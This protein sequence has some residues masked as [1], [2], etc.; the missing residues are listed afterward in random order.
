MK[1][2]AVFAALALSLAA[3]A[4]CE[5]LDFLNVGGVPLPVTTPTPISPAPMATPPVLLTV[6]P[7]APTFTPYPGASRDAALGPITPANAG[8]LAL[9]ATIPHQNA[10]DITWSPDGALLAVLAEGGVW[11]YDIPQLDT[12][13]IQLPPSTS[14]GV[15]SA[16]FSPDGQ[17]LAVVSAGMQGR[18]QVFSTDAWRVEADIPV[19]DGKVTYSPDG[20]YLAVMGLSAGADNLPHR[21]V[22]IRTVALDSHLMLPVEDWVVDLAFSSDG[23]QILTA[24]ENFSGTSC[25]DTGTAVQVRN[26]EDGTI[27]YTLTPEGECGYRWAA[28]YA[29]G[30]GIIATGNLAWEDPKVVLRVWDARTGEQIAR[31][32][33]QPVTG[34]T[35]V[36]FSPYESLLVWM[37]PNGALN[38]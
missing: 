19:Q 35:R 5:W 25:P 10:F 8:R 6:M 30:R 14:E 12:P 36:V 21:A 9:L 29:S 38:L 31:L 33:E 34:R 2:L 13:V 26:T 28:A 37:L 11:V 32:A 15:R 23:R 3:L 24:S 27:V 16:A 20:Q 4:R 17:R 1:P 7:Q 18:L 22:E